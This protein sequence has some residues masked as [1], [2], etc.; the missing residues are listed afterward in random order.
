[1][2]VPDVSLDPASLAIAED[3]HIRENQGFALESV[4]VR[5]VTI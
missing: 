1:M 3:T 2:T 5:G 4:I